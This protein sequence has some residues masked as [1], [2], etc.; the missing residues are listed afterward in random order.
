MINQGFSGSKVRKTG[1]WVEKE[2]ADQAFVEDT[3]R[4]ADLR[5]L[6]RRL[7]CLPEIAAVR[8]AVIRMA[9]IEGKEGLTRENAFEAGRALRE[10]HEVK[11]FNHP[12]H[13]GIQ[14]LVEMA[15]EN[16]AEAGHEA[17]IAANL[18]EH[19]PA[20][21]LIHAE[22]VQFIEQQDGQIVFI[23]IEETGWGSRYRDL[24]FVHYQ[25]YLS[26]DRLARESFMRGY[27]TRPIE[28][29]PDHI[30][31]IAGLTAVAYARFADPEKRL[32]L[33]LALINQAE[34]GNAPSAFEPS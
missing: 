6:A 33:G 27:T 22:P 13:T 9:F 10:L 1:R 14:W 30:Q 28:I 21:A 23:D 18:S 17:R 5:A 19:Y 32:S 25:T 15:N 24:G 3:K 16:L 4:Q 12:C 20:D 2:S 8:R 26:G 31:Q 7:A 11:G 29:D 34:P